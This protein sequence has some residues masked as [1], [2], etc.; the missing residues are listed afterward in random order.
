MRPDYNVRYGTCN[1]GR[2]GSRLMTY[3]TIRTQ[4]VGAVATVTLD[5]PEAMN[6][7]TPGMLEELHHAFTAL[8]AD[9]SVRVVVLTGSGRAFSAGVDLKALQGM[10]LEGGAV[11]D[12][13]DVPARNFIETMRTMG[14]IVIAAV[15]GYC[16]TGALELAL[17]ADLM[18]V[19]EEA[20]L[21]D[22]H[23]KFGLR[24]TWGMS[25]RL[26]AAVGPARAHLL[27]YTARRFSGREAAAWGL[28]A[29]AVPRD[30]LDE[31]VSSLAAEVAAN[32]AGSLAA[33]KDLFRANSR[34]GAEEGLAYEAG[35]GYDIPDTDE[36]LQE[37]R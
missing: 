18:V 33:Y 11:G 29:L 19:A 10:S 23:A 25:Q 8:A 12:V 14:A 35:H 37:F 13:L 21:A 26:P 31:T 30:Q 5:R 2:H 22:T 34:L 36:R 32:S 24:P 1:S 27:S 4:I 3:E 16:F 9:T 17:A 7:I 15:N 28:A 6:A 20:T